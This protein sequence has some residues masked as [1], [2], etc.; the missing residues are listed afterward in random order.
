[1]KIITICGSLKY[2]DEI[3]KITEELTLQGNCI[4]SIIYPVNHNISA[5][6]IE[7]REMFGAM[8]RERI[9]LSD[10][11]MVVNIDDYI[12]ESTRQEIEFARSLNKEILYY[13]D[14]TT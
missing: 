8:H 6:S 1:M 13:T 7:E 2:K 9:R 14:F 3:M 11:I 10:A 4:L 5:Y 12:G